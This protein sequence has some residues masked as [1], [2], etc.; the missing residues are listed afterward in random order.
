MGWPEKPKL[1]TT[2]YQ[3]LQMEQRAATIGKKILSGDKKEHISTAPT[4]GISIKID[5]KNQF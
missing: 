1:I 2:T 3:T 5:S 4:N